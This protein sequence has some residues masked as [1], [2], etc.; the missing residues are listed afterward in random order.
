MGDELDDYLN[1]LQE[2]INEETRQ[3]Y[4]QAVYERWRE[5]KYMGVMEKPDGYGRLTGSCGDTMEIFLMFDRN[6]VKEASFT[7]TGCG[8]SAVCGSFA[9]EIA[10]GKTPDELADITGDSVLGMT[11]PLPEEDQHCAFLAA[12]T[13]QTALEDYM[14]QGRTDS[15]EWSRTKND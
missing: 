12:E 10:H 9:A 11:G 5:P 7:T 1:N 2:M 14:K 4:G 3:V 15:W 8:T 13:L 6:K